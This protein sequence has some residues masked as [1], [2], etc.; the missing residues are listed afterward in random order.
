[1]PTD[2]VVLHVVA[3][4]APAK[5]VEEMHDLDI[6]TM[7]DSLPQLALMMLKQGHA[8]GA[9]RFVFVIPS[10]VEM[11]AAGHA[12]TCAGAEAVRVLALSAARQWIADGVT[13]NCI[14]APWPYA[15]SL[16]DDIGPIVEFLASEA[17]ANVSGETIRI[18]GPDQGL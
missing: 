10:I 11:G 7:Y 14:S 12:A 6:Q 9:T 5:P 15:E 13:V 18:G 3:P 1:M 8:D 16:E 2:G 17:G 4:V